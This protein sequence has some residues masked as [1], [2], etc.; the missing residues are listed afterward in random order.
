MSR[1]MVIT[2]WRVMPGNAELAERRSDDVAVHDEENIFAG[3]FADIAVGIER[4]AFDVAIGARFHANEL[5]IH[6]ICGGF[7]HLRAVCCGAGAIPGTDA[8][9][10]AGAQTFFAEIFSPGI[11]GEVDLD[12]A[13][14]R[15]HSG[16]A[17]AAQ[18]D[19][20]M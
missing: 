16:F 1:Q 18:H 3:T 14:Q 17:V 20:R 7:G 6:V 9:V 19:G 15:I 2:D 10:H 8:N 12:G 5:G 4:D 13:A 11:A